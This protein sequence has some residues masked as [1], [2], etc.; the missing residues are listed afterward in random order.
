MDLCA[1]QTSCRNTL[2][3]LCSF[4]TD[5]ALHMDHEYAFAVWHWTAT[6]AKQRWQKPCD[7]RGV[8]VNCALFY[9]SAAASNSAVRSNCMANVCF[10]CG[11]RHLRAFTAESFASTAP[12]RRRARSNSLEHPAAP[13]LRGWVLRLGH[14][15]CDP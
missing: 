3:L 4:V 14:L 11:A 1:K 10:P 12:R 5:V 6:L 7:V 15:E 8:L 13:L 2:W 9:C